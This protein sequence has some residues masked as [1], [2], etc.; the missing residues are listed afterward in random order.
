VTEVDGKVD[1]G[2]CGVGP[3]ARSTAQPTTR[4]VVRTPTLAA[5][6]VR[7]TV[8]PATDPAV[9]AGWATTRAALLTAFT[10]ELL[11]T[12]LDRYPETGL[13]DRGVRH[14]RALSL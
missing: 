2:C 11:S 6:S 7:P 10:V 5:P 9:R 14:V 13:P 3:P 1:E 4:A 8:R 12:G